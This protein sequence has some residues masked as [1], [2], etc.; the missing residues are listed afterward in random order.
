MVD[1]AMWLLDFPDVMSVSSTMYKHKTRGVEDTACTFIRLKN[2]ITLSIDVS[3]TAT[4]EENNYYCDV[5]GTKGSARINPLRIHKLM[6]GNPVNVT[7][8]LGDPLV[9]YFKHSY[10]RE[11]KHFIGAVKRIHRNIST[12]DEAIHRMKLVEAVYASAQKKKEISLK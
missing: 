8:V 11:L 6:A 3:W 7:P 1:L 9:N 4:V 5:I 12:G 2:D 10:E